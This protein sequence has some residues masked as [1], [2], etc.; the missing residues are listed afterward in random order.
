MQQLLRIKHLSAASSVSS[1]TWPGANLQ[2][3]I[4]PRKILKN[5]KNNPKLHKPTVGCEAQLA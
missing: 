1:V 4:I 2:Q 5:T 3:K